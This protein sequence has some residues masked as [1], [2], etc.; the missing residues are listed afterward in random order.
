[1]EVPINELHQRTPLFIGSSGMVETAM[2]FMSK[3]SIENV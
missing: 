2:E 1:M 3:Y